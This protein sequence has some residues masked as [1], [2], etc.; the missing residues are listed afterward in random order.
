M[1]STFARP[2]RAAGAAGAAVV[3]IAMIIGGAAPSAFAAPLPDSVNAPLGMCTPAGGFPAFDPTNIPNPP[4][5]ED[6]GPNVYVGGDFRASTA[7]GGRPAEVEGLLV[8]AGDATFDKSFNVGVA[9]GSNVRPAAGDPMLRVGGDVDITDPTASLNVGTGYTTG[10]APGGTVHV[11]G[12]F[13][14]STDQISNNDALIET[15]IGATAALDTYAGF[16]AQ[17]DGYSTS[18]DAL[19]ANGTADTHGNRRR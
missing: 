12:G 10:N 6:A 11:G 17:L 3:G 13:T 2:K 1:E 19:T 16:D 4:V 8:V 15:N 9:I 18:L 7:D 5:V 14:P